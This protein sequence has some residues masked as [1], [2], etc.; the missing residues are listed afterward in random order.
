MKKKYAVCP[1]WVT[2]RSDGER[3]YVDAQALVSLY[4]VNPSECVVAAPSRER[5]RQQQFHGL[6]ELRPRSD[7][8]YK[9]PKPA[10]PKPLPCPFCGCEDVSFQEGNTFRW[11]QVVCCVCGA[12]CGEVRIQTLGEGSKEEW[13]AE[14]KRAAVKEWNRRPDSLA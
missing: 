2:S 7:G 10:E 5:S 12:R 13:E 4:G 3:H 1:D 9:L 6:I 14:V 8:N 11:L